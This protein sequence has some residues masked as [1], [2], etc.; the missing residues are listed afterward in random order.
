MKHRGPDEDAFFNN[1]K[2]AIGMTRLAIIDL[3][4]GLYP[5]RNED[6]SLLLFYNGEIY[7]FHE[8]RSQLIA[9]GHK[10]TSATDGEVIVHAYEEWGPEC[11]K[12]FNGMWAFAIWNTNDESLFISRD[13]FGIKPLYYTISESRFCYASEIRAL[14]SLPG[15]ETKPNEKLIYDYL[16]DGRVDH[17]EETFFTGIYRLMPAHYATLT[18]S[19]AFEKTRYWSM[20]SLTEVT[21]I[22]FA[23]A[24]HNVRKLFIDAVRIRLISDVPVGT[25]LSGGLDS[26]SIVGTIGQLKN[27]EKESIGKKLQTFSASFPADSIDESGFAGVVTQAN[28]VEPNVIY[29]CAAELWKEMQ[30]FIRTL[31]EPFVSSNM[32]AQWKVMQAA[33][34]R[35]VTVLLDGQGGDELFAGYIEYIPSYIIDLFRKRKILTAFREGIQSL[36]ITFPLILLFLKTGRGI[37][38]AFY[39]YLNGEFAAEM[40]SR[41]SEHRL[42]RLIK[43]E[44]SQLLKDDASRFVLP[45]LLRYEDKS[46]M[47]FSIETRLPFLDQRL[48]EYVASLPMQFKIRGGWTKGVFRHA[49]QGILPKE[50]Q[51]RRSKIGFETPQRRWLTELSDRIDSLL[52]SKALSSKFVDLN[53]LLELLRTTRKLSVLESGI[54]WRWIC[55]ELWLREFFPEP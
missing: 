19:G 55:L 45:G 6:G 54:L 24:S 35:R 11:V 21:D 32:Y 44:S 36:D 41:G 3:R 29:P 49:M 46:S 20:D 18:V 5:I 30:E 25:C 17:T 2:C 51:W 48:V 14:L 4:K 15:I 27:E 31:E 28:K 16:V 52:S 34:S 12:R 7:N 40:R 22:T 33:K 13:H 1:T 38:N 39:P 23:E 37:D 9:A 8:L 10:F 47:H 42:P 26:S 43:S 50:I 53:A